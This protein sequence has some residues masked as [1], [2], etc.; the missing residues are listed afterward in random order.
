MG[1]R[2]IEGRGGLSLSDMT[3]TINRKITILDNQGCKTNKGS[4]LIDVELNTAV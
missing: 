3:G 1:V 4:T 2:K